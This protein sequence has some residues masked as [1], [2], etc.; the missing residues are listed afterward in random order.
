MTKREKLLASA[1]RNPA[2]LSFR[3]LESLLEQCGWTFKRQA[4]SH[5][6]WKAPSGPVVPI[7]S[8]HGKAKEYQVR[9]ILRIMENGDE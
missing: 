3:E 8:D 7:Q 9:Q 5:R 2:G 4:G 6:V 1:Q